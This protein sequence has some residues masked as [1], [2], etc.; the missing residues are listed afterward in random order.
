MMMMT[1]LAF[2]IPTTLSTISFR[3]GIKLSSLRILKEMMIHKKLRSKRRQVNFR[4]SSGPQSIL[5]HLQ[6]QLQMSRLTQQT[7]T[8][9][10]E[11]QP[12]PIHLKLTA[13]KRLQV[14]SIVRRESRNLWSVNWSPNSLKC[15][16][17]S[18]P[19]LKTKFSGPPR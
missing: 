12:L 5:G 16:G 18:T 15:R 1:I 17:T 7:I 14:T 3:K 13:E 4:R 11:L 19:F 6:L 8:T 9:K 2:L 10:E